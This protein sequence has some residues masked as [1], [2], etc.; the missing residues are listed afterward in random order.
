VAIPSGSGSEI[1][2]SSYQPAVSNSAVTLISTTVHA[3]VT[4]IATLVSVTFTEMA[5]QTDEEINLY[6]DCGRLTIVGASGNDLYLLKKQPIGAY[7]T[8]VFSDKVVIYAG[9]ALKVI[10]TAAANVDVMANWI[11]QDW[12]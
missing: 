11:L 8:F 9:D 10:T 7:A 5:G 3:S 2:K 12:T 4:E 1:L 6:V